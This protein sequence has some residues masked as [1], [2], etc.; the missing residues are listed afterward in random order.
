MG[1]GE[2]DM[3]HASSECGAA[4]MKKF[5]NDVLKR[6]AI[7][8]SNYPLRYFDLIAAVD[9]FVL[10]D[11][12]QFTKN[13]WPNRNVIKTPRGTEWISV[14]VVKNIRRRIRDFSLPGS[15]RQEKHW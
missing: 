6:I 3:R 12:V 15:C 14:P 10:Y 8:Q 11:Y 13:D 2:G 1:N 9:E 5:S 4:P 7:I